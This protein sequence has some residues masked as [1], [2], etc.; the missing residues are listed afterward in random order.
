MFISIYKNCIALFCFIFLFCFWERERKWCLRTT[1]KKL[2]TKTGWSLWQERW[3]T[4]SGMSS[5]HGGGW[6]IKQTDI[7]QHPLSP[8]LKPFKSGILLT[9]IT[10]VVKYFTCLISWR[11]KRE[12]DIPQRTSMSPL[13]IIWGE[14][15]AWALARR[16]EW[17][18][19]PWICELLSLNIGSDQTSDQRHCSKRR[20]A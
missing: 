9:I 3:G 12:Q 14:K 19:L 5:P 2:K 10:L 13:L 15:M 20:S 18:S 6:I 8:C 16:R 17:H 11:D 7:C 4:K 1:Y